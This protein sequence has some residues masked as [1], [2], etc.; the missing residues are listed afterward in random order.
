MAASDEL[1]KAI[2]NI[3]KEVLVTAHDEEDVTLTAT[4]IDPAGK[5]NASY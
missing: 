3:L 4:I 5:W 1:R 2:P